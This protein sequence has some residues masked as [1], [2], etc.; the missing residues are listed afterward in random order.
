MTALWQ[1]YKNGQVS[2]YMYGFWSGQWL[3]SASRAQ[4]LFSWEAVPG[5]CPVYGG[6][7]GSGRG[8]AQREVAAPAAVGRTPFLR[9]NACGLGRTGP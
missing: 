5:L 3:S 6:I 7:S 1:G 2:P 4:L 8:T 9:D